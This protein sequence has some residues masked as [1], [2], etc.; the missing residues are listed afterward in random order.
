MNTAQ[1]SF[2]NWYRSC[3][4]WTAGNH[5][6]FSAN[7]GRVHFARHFKLLPNGLS[8]NF[9]TDAVSLRRAALQSL[10]AASPQTG[11]G[12]LYRRVSL[13]EARRY[14]EMSQREGF[15]LPG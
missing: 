15:R 9:E 14:R 2:R 1:Q 6:A 4:A 10:A 11:N 12:R 8:N 3:R 5:A 13:E 7:L